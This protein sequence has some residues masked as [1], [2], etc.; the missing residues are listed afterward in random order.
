MK[1]KRQ[2]DTYVGFV[3]LDEGIDLNNIA[4]SFFEY[5]FINKITA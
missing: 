5:N 4:S 1:F 2:I 3:P